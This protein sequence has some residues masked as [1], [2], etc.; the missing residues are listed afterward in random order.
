MGKKNRHKPKQRTFTINIYEDGAIL[1]NGYIKQIC[2]LLAWAPFKSEEVI[3]TFTN[4]HSYIDKINKI[5]INMTECDNTNDI[6]SQI[7]EL[8]DKVYEYYQK[9]PKSDWAKAIRSS[10]KKALNIMKM[11]M[12]YVVER[13]LKWGVI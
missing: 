11:L 3:E 5:N 2:Y 7:S 8:R 6:L 4:I 12:D 9:D 1:A 13:V 10:N